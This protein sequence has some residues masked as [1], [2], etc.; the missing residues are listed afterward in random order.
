[1]AAVLFWSTSATA[2]K[3]TLGGMN[4]TQLLFYSSLTSTIVFAAF[5]LSKRNDSFGQLFTKD[6]ILAGIKLGLLNPFMYYLILF[7]AYSLLQAQEALALN[8]TWPIAISIFSWI[9]LKQEMT[10]KL[11]LGLLLAFIGVVII[12][13]R[14]DVFSFSFESP[15]GI[16]LALITSVFW[17]AYWIMNLMDKRDRY[18]KLFT[19]FLFGTIF[20]TIYMLLFDSFIPEKPTAL[21][22]A[23]YIGLFEMGLTFILWLKGLELSPNKTKSSTLAYLSPFLSFG[24]IALVLGEK[25]ILSSIIGLLLIIGGIMTQH[26][27][28]TKEAAIKP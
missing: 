3:L 17:A 6:K 28:F 16:T 1:M 24:F 4:H 11:I 23:V 13:T 7:K 20:I 10:K 18:E 2:F 15:L 26:I 9:F 25:L 14:G 8:F 21:L 22:G 19:A 27:R 5:Y 12:S